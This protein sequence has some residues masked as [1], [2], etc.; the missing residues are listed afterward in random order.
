MESTKWIW[1]ST[2]WFLLFLW[3]G[4]NENSLHIQFAMSNNFNISYMPFILAIWVIP[5]QNAWRRQGLILE[6][7]RARTFIY[8]IML[9]LFLRSVFQWSLSL[10]PCK[11]CLEFPNFCC[12]RTRKLKLYSPHFNVAITSESVTYSTFIRPAS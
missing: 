2:G 9:Y 1:I 7:I 4:F 8:Q 5:K 12:H 11:L 3:K 6:E 10:T